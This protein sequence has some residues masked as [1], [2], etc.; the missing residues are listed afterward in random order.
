MI[1]NE[2]LELSIL[3]KVNTELIPERPLDGIT[4]FL[5][6]L[7]RVDVD[8]TLDRGLEPAVVHNGSRSPHVPVSLDDHIHEFVSHSLFPSLDAHIR[9]CAAGGAPE[10][11][12]A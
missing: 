7:R 1:A 8:V 12:L 2:E 9:L 3:A 10:P 4:D 5:V 11:L 6:E